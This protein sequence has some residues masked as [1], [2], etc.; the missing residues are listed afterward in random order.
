MNTINLLSDA[1]YF[2]ESNTKLAEL[3]GQLDGR[4]VR[5]KLDAMK[6]LLAMMTLG[7]DVSAFFPD[8]VKN[9]IVESVEVKKLVYMFLITYSEQHQDLALLSIN[10]FQKDLASPSQRIRANALKAMSSIRIPIAVPLVMLA[11]KAAVKDNSSYVKRAAACAIPKVH[12]IEPVEQAESLIEFIAE[13]LTSIEPTVLGPTL[14]AFQSVCPTRYDLLH[15]H[16]RKICHLLADFDEW[17]QVV[18]L[19]VLLRY[20]R[21]QFLSP[22][23]KETTDA[24]E[25]GKAKRGREK[26]KGKE[27][28]KKAKS[29]KKKKSKGFYSDEDEEE[30][31]EEAESTSGDDSSSLSDGDVAAPALVLDEDHALLLRQSQSLLQ[32]ANSAVILSIVT[33]HW[34]LAP[35]SL[36][37][38]CVPPLVRL[39]RNKRSIQYVLLTNI[40]SMAKLR[41]S[42]FSPF[43]KDFYVHQQDAAYVKSLKLDVLSYIVDDATIPSVI[44]ELAVYVLDVDKEFV[45]E[46]IQCLGRCAIRLQQVA[47]RAMAILMRLVT[48]SHDAV[49][50]QAVVTLRQLLQSHT[51]LHAPVV[52]RM[53][54]LLP[55]VHIPMARTA[56]VWMIGE[57]R[58]CIPTSAPDCLRL[59]ASTFKDEADLVKQQILNLAVKLFLANPRQ[60]SLLFKYVMDLCKYDVN[61]DIRDRARLLRAL[62]FKKK[63]TGG[64]GGGGQAQAGSGGQAVGSEVKEA[65]KGLFLVAKPASEVDDR[66]SAHDRYLLGTMSHSLGVQVAGYG[67][68]PEFPLIAPSGEV[69]KPKEEEEVRK[70]EGRRG[71]R[72]GDSE[73]SGSEASGS[74]ES[75]FSEFDSEGSGGERGSRSD[76]RSRS[77][78][79]EGSGSASDSASSGSEGE[80]RRKR[81]AKEKA[82]AREEEKREK[83]REKDR[84]KDRDRHSK[85]RKDSDSD[86]DS[87]GSESDRSDN[88]SRSSASDSRSDS[89]S[90]DAPSHHRK[91]TEKEK[92]K[93]RQRKEKEKERERQEREREEKAKKELD[94]GRRKGEE[95][96]GGKPSLAASADLLDL[97]D[98][99]DV[100]PPSF[101]PAS[102]PLIPLSSTSSLPSSS[103][104]SSSPSPTPPPPPPTLLGLHYPT[105]GQHGQLLNPITSSG[106]RIDYT[107]SRRPSLYGPRLIDLELT[108]VNESTAPFKG[109]GLVEEERGM[110]GDSGGLGD[111]ADIGE[112]GVGD[113]RVVKVRVDFKGKVQPR[114]WRVSAGE[115]DYAVKLTPEVGELMKPVVVGWKEWEAR[116]KRLTG[117][118]EHGVEVRVREAGVRRMAQAMVEVCHIGVLGEG[119]EGGLMG[120]DST[121]LR[122]SGQRL[123]NDGWVLMKLTVSGRDEKGRGGRVQVTVHCDDFL[124]GTK[125]ADL[126]KKT[127]A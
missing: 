127:L 80:A 104:S 10:T 60:T 61:Y 76:S 119:E 88:E 69:R 18:A 24:G 100:A 51:G 74:E 92:D 68:L 101:P 56:I 81:R 106:L 79:S 35:S 44:K 19:Q 99:T 31:E 30:E 122:L 47:D 40:L 72:G 87:R 63:D 37:H 16:Y 102:A 3:R 6:K 121:V 115:G 123:D 46:A 49:V 27:R 64:G 48:S 53:V 33:L 9:V 8:V 73:D 114:V 82:K 124:F 84:G 15:P 120:D 105:R 20:G 65:L 113:M 11:L 97:N 85:R 103:S 112:L 14:F 96:K 66:L 39:S 41:P 45:C 71:R 77:S 67:E 21:T 95:K 83:E 117:M 91:Q 42:L 1:R 110:E 2:D 98:L 78:R 57:Y 50:A 89:N 23:A 125:L 4:V 34:Y 126:A 7:R 93:E 28:E 26:G 58:D 17:G 32:S 94:K 90:D 107:F 29:K 13:L 22:Y 12:S 108:L 52:K 109:L 55:R 25:A 62:F 54:R 86:S 118:S 38:V 43:I 59:L 36:C 70:G 111:V 5:D 116:A 75:D